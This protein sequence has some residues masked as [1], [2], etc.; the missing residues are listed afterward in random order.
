MRRAPATAL[1]VLL[2]ALTLGACLLGASG[3]AATMVPYVIGGQRASTAQY[4]W[5]VLVLSMPSPTLEVLCGGSILDATHI[6]TAAHCIDQQGTTVPYPSSEVRVLAGADSV[7]S[8]EEEGIVPAGAQLSAAALVRAHPDYAPLPGI[9]DDVAV[10]TL[11][12]PLK[13]SAASRTAA[14]GLV[15]SGATPAPG[16]SLTVSGYGKENGLEGKEYEP[17][18]YLYAAGLT[19]ISSDACRNAVGV[20]SAVLLC[21][22]S[23]TSS[24]CEG[25]SGGPLTEG[26]PAVQV[27]IVD[28]GGKSCPVGS[29]NVFT[30]VAAPEIRAFIEGSEAPPLAARPTG[31]PVLHYL[32][33]APVDYSP[34]TCDP[35]SWSAP[36]AFSYTFQTEG[37]SPQVLQSGPGNT[38]APVSGAVGLSIVCVVQAANAGGVSTARSGGSPPLTLDTAPPAARIS[39]RPRCHLRACTLS[40]RAS[41]PNA[42]ALTIAASASYQVSTRCTVVHGHRRASVP[43]RRTRTLPMRLTG[44]GPAY[45]ASIK[46]LPYGVRVRFAVSARNAAGLHQGTPSAASATLAAPRNSTQKH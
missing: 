26:T 4:P 25:D 6:L 11:A 36:A 33:S 28:F 27:G 42:V 2:T 17:D 30:N 34:M 10:I 44:S 21:A 14:I 1:A 22:G 38:F 20:N 46:G 41:D 8:F 24:A 35:G 29:A 3:A 31:S 18:G 39:G 23:A 45:S 16:T 37:P 9:R 12:A 40:L 7:Y 19:A 15:E 13:L 43:C 5:Q 32:G